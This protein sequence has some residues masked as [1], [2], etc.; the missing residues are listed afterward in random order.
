MLGYDIQAM[1]PS[2]KA[3]IALLIEGHVQYSFMTVTEIERFYARFYPRW[4]R[5]I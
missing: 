5:E 2:V 1:P 3:Q 4:K